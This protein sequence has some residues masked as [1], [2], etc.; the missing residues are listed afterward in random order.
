[1][2]CVVD[3]RRLF[4][5]LSCVRWTLPAPSN[6]PG[7]T[8][9]LVFAP[10]L[11]IDPIW[12]TRFPDPVF[13]AKLQTNAK[14]SL[15]YCIQHFWDHSP[16]PARYRRDLRVELELLHLTLLPCIVA[17]LG[18]TTAAAV[19]PLQVGSIAF[20]HFLLSF[21]LFFFPSHLGF[22]VIP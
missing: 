20:P 3:L 9:Q 2:L 13:C 7:F 14:L 15:P 22:G 4:D 10:A 6:S 17:R 19:T 21:Y 16:G 8:P 18:T 11:Y 5:M 1:M 12:T